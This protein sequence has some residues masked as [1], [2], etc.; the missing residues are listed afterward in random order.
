MPVPE[1]LIIDSTK[2][3]NMLQIYPCNSL[4]SSNNMSW[5]GIHLKHYLLL[6]H[7]IPENCPKQ[8]LI[9]I[10]TQLSGQLQIQQKID[11]RF[12]KN[13]IRQGDIIVVPANASVQASWDVKHH[14]IDISFAPEK[15]L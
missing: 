14:C 1:S 2:E 10:H 4:L 9:L 8:H 3:D 13:R 15:L 6:P 5:D 11:D 7:S 12:E